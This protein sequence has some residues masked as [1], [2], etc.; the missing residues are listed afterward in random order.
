MI[1]L[2]FVAKRRA[3]IPTRRFHEDWLTQHGRIISDQAESLGMRKYVQSHLVDLPANEA[4]RS[5]R[6][7]LPPFDGIAEIWWDSLDEMLLAS[8]SPKGRVATALIEKDAARLVDL[9]LSTSFLTKEHL[10]FDRSTEIPLGPDAVKVTFLLK[11]KEGMSMA[12][13]QHT[14]LHDHGK[15]ATSFADISHLTKYVQSHTL[16]NETNETSNEA[17]KPE[18]S[19]DGLTEIWLRSADE[20]RR[21]V[22]TEEGRAASAALLADERR[23]VQLDQS[24]CFVTREHVIF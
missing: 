17:R 13:C 12:D 2:V 18:S 7:M 23:F 24:H 10:I 8:T 20:L 9:E 19:F 14:W 22:E 5:S 11:R 6:G 3:D 1:K 15:L 4:L 16:D 21:G